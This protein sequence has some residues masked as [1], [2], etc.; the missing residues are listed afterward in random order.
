[1]PRDFDISPYFEIVKP[2]IVHGFDYTALHWAD[3]QKPL[4]EVAGQFGVFPETIRSPSLVPEAFDE[5]TS[6]PAREIVLIDD[7]LT[8]IDCLTVT[9]VIIIQE[10]SDIEY[11]ESSPPPALRA[12][13]PT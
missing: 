5:E 7:E 10:D 13:R 2:T 3:K 1:M 9:E 11:V 4:Q 8:L 12:G 6:F